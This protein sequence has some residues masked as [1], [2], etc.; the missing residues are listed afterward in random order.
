MN[1]KNNNLNKMEKIK[2][3][4]GHHKQKVAAKMTDEVQIALLLNHIN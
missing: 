2:I 1:K 3:V 4:N